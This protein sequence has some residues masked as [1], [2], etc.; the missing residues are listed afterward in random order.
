MSL[1]ET[2]FYSLTDTYAM[3]SGRGETDSDGLVGLDGG[4]IWLPTSVFVGRI[5]INRLP[6]SFVSYF[7]QES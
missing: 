7:W 5:C 2:L 1:A 6:V 3:N 4:S